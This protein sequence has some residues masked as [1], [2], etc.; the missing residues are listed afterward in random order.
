MHPAID[1]V[2]STVTHP[3]FSVVTFF[4]GLLGGH[5]WA[6]SRDRRK[7]YNAIAGHIRAALLEEVGPPTRV[8]YPRPKDGLTAHDADAIQFFMGWWQ[9][10]RFR[11]AV[12]EYEKAKGQKLHIPG[13]RPSGYYSDPGLVRISAQRLLD[14][15]P[16]R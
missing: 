1:I 11:H 3:A 2:L 8:S 14:L 7:D 10:R 9:R 5:R 12:A 13:A 15:V 4:I 16:L 6:L